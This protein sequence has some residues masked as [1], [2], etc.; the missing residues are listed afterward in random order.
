MFQFL[1]K[2]S[3]YHVVQTTLKFSLAS[4]KDENNKVE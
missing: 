2:I 1:E 3:K 4:E